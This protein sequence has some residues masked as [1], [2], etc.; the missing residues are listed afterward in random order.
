MTILYNANYGGFCLG[1]GAEEFFI[2][3]GYTKEQAF[4]LTVGRCP[5]HLPIL[6]EAFRKFGSGW[7]ATIKEKEADSD[8]YSISEHDGLEEVVFHYDNMSCI[9]DPSFKKINWDY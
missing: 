1:E 9:H 5:R 7:C 6:I 8:I 2:E 4:C 3:K